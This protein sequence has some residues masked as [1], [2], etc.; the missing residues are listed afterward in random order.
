[1]HC[2][3]AGLSLLLFLVSLLV[4]VLSFLLRLMRGQLKPD[5]GKDKQMDIIRSKTKQLSKDKK[6]EDESGKP[7]QTSRPASGDEIVEDAPMSIMSPPVSPIMM[8]QTPEQVARVARDREEVAAQ[9]DAAMLAVQGKAAGKS[10]PSPLAKLDIGLF[11]KRIVGF[12]ARNFFNMKFA[13]LTIAFIINFLLLFYKA[14]VVENGND[15]GAEAAEMELDVD[16]A[17]PNDEDENSGDTE[18]TE[19][20]DEDE[21]PDEWIHVDHQFYYIEYIIIVLALIHAFVSF[22]MVIA[23]YNLKVPLGIF[24]REKEVARRMEFDGLY[25]CEQPEDD[26]IKAHWDK[27]VISA[28]SFPSLY[29]DKFI[30]KRVRQKYSDQFEFD[31]INMILGMEKSAISPQ[32]DPDEA[33]GGAMQAVLSLDWRYQVWKAGVTV[34]DNAFL[35]QL[36]YFIFSIL[37]NYNYFFFAA[38]LI[39]VAVGV[40]ALRIILQAIT[41]NGKQLVLT[42]MLLIIIVYIY[43]VIAFNFFRKFYVSE[44]EEGEPDA[45]CHDMLTCFVFHLYKGVRAGGGIGDEIEP[46]DGDE[47]EYV[48]ILFDISFFFFIIVILL[49]II[50]GFIIDAF[51]ALRDQM[52][53]VEDELENNCFIC[54]IGKDYFDKVPHGF[55]IHVQKEHNLAN[56]LFFVQYLIEKDENDYTGQETLVWDMYQNRCWDFFPQGD[57]FRKQYE[58]ELGGGGD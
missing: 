37:G 14:T 52:Q 4:A 25:I 3:G 28:K 38:H 50:Q 7:S 44:E 24:K 18:D 32:P 11:F 57:C 55:D 33:G 30:K 36:M 10:E 43:T 20:D 41:H 58:A 54:G 8:I 19:G 46:P 21:P 45:K 1:L 40:P 47:Y 35:Y 9:Q 31:Q 27:L 13:A 26:D 29:W 15:D 12:L 49:A 6:E 39:D 42:V 16:D 53:G 23:Y 48:R 22:C 5:E 34:T 51:G 56:Y 2:A 17:V